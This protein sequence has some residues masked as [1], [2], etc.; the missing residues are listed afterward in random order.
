MPMSTSLST[1]ANFMFDKA[2]VVIISQTTKP[3]P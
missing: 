3:L 1:Y 2:K